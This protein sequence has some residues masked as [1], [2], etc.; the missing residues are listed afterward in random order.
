[1]SNQLSSEE[2][3]ALLAAIV[4]S[5][6][7]AI[8]SKDLNGVVQSWNTSAERIF[9][10]RAE[11]IIGQMI[12]KII[13]VDRLHEEPQILDRIRRGE[14]VD[15]FQT[16]RVR[17]DGTLIHVSVTI[18]PI[19]AADGTIIG[20]SKVARDIT[21]QLKL[22]SQ[23]DELLEAERAA[24]TQAERT[25]RM[26]DEFLA[27]LGHELR[28]PLNAILGWTT[29]LE[30]ETLSPD[31]AE[32]VEV[33]A[34]NARVQKQLIEDLLDMSRIISGKIRL[35]VQRVDV[36]AVIEAALATVRPAA[37][38][39]NV[40]LH[41]TLDPLAGPVK[42]DPSRLQQVVWN[43]LS[44]AI[45][46]TEKGGRV[47]VFLE[48]VNSHVEITVAD[49]GRGIKPEFLPHVFD[50]FRQED[51]S[52]A[53]RHGGLGLGL[54]IV[55]QL[56]ELH[57]GTVR[58][59]SPGEGQGATFSLDL[60]LL[61]LND[62]GDGEPPRVHP[63]APG[64]APEVFCESQQLA[65]V[66]VLV[67]DDE[68]DARDVVRRLLENCEATVLTA[69]SAAEALDILREHPADVLIS[70][71]GMPV[72][73]GYELIRKVRVMTALDRA[74]VPA[75]ALT[76]FARSE[77][78]MRAML[79]GFDLHMSKPIEPTELVVA[80]ASMTRRSANARKRGTQ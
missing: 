40:R 30:S 9:G 52:A 14:R 44:N 71:I 1:M 66:T 76:A 31:A 37:D 32:G 15:H 41:V 62:T 50:R 33:I 75:I 61:V 65:G 46:F 3:Q 27:T 64:Q 79:A 11:E 77:D 74:H 7:D 39:K 24:R 54:S 38:A 12:T 59:K 49:N 72:V 48:R 8:V 63:T 80:V 5:S 68:P 18:S 35:D 2:L 53:R 22:M 42:G 17:K 69:S 19:R 13:P 67:V 55:K 28:T 47:Q 58:A 25:S 36:S 21:E 78:R 34:R 6:D 20:A 4:T 70:D 16:L 60:P 10:W 23:R 29:L 43:L 56:V 26:K 57:G 73:D 45:K 51:A